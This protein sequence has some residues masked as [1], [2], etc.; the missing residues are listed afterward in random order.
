MAILLILVKSTLADTL[1]F[2]LS[3]QSYASSLDI[4]FQNYGVTLIKS[5]IAHRSRT[6]L[7][8]TI[9]HNVIL[10]NLN[11]GYLTNITVSV[12]LIIV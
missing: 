12:L 6:E 5:S 3:T 7:R 9:L 11:V 8:N 4:Y 10:L 2:F 1:V